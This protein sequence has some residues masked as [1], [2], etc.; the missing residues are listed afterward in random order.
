MSINAK[1]IQDLEDKGYHY[2]EKRSKRDRTPSEPIERSQSDGIN[3]VVIFFMMFIIAI[4]LLVNIGFSIYLYSIQYDPGPQ[5]FID[6]EVDKNYI[7]IDS[8]SLET[9]VKVTNYEKKSYDCIISISY[10]PEGGVQFG[11]NHEFTLEK[12]ET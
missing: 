5:V 9:T 10:A 6:I 4:L 1:M 11:K 8:P 7:I 3:P 12:K 2:R